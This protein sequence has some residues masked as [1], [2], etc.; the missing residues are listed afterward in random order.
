MIWYGTKNVCSTRKNLLG[1]VN[2]GFSDECLDSLLDFGP[3]GLNLGGLCIGGIRDLQGFILLL[4]VVYHA[5]HRHDLL[6][7]RPVY[8]RRL[9]R[10]RQ[11][12]I[13]TR[14]LTKKPNKNYVINWC[15]KTN[16]RRYESDLVLNTVRLTLCSGGTLWAT[17]DQFIALCEILLLAI[18]RA[19]STYGC[20][21]QRQEI[22]HQRQYE[23]MY[24]WRFVSEILP[25]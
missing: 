13:I 1:N 10:V 23:F 22:R 4:E 16:L 7:S 8:L 11:H 5:R 18:F 3:L 24:F 12:P 25:L 19:T 20:H 17:T 6:V 15:Q 21:E 14:L 2:I 9:R